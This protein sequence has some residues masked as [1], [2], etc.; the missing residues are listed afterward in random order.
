MGSEKWALNEKTEPEFTK[1]YQK[2]T[3]N[4]KK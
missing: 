2:V 1:N 4:G 3:K